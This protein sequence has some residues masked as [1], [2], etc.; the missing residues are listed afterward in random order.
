M[1]SSL[2]ERTLKELEFFFNCSLQSDENQSCLINMGIGVSLQ[3]EL[4]SNDD[5]IMASVLGTLPM[6]RY[7]DNLIRQALK[8]NNASLP[9]QGIFSFSAKTNHLILFLLIDPSR[10]NA[11]SVFKILPPFIEK[12]K[13]WK[14]AIE[15]GDT[16]MIASKQGTSSSQSGLFGLIR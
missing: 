10:L 16:P 12:V 8:S 7:R 15:A 13:L 1:I 4:D 9:S 14:E 5:L 6:G 3:L 2:F 11:D